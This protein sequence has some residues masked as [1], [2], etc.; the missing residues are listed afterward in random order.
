LLHHRPEILNSDN[1]REFV[2]AII[3]ELNGMW[4]DIKIAHGKLRYS[5]S[6][7]L[8]ERANRDV[9]DFATWNAEN[10]SKAWPW[11]IKFV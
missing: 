7:W 1:G 2:N 9:E 5:Q 3:T 6:Q 8:V 11:E 4:G 10:N